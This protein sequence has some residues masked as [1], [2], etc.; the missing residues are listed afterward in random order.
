MLREKTNK[1]W[2]WLGAVLCGVIVLGALAA[3]IFLNLP[4]PPPPPPETEPTYPQPEEAEL[5][6]QDFQYDGQYL[7]CISAPSELGID[8]SQYQGDVDWAAVKEAGVEFVIIRLGGRGY[9]AEGV[10]YTDDMAETYYQGAKEAGLKVGVYFFSQAITA[11]E[12]QEEAELTLQIIE[13]WDLQMPVVYDWEV[14]EA[15]NSRTRNVD[16]RTITD[17]MKA[18]CRVIQ[19]AGREAMIYFNPDLSLEKVY[20]DEISIYRFWLAHYTEW[21]TYPYKVDMWQYTNVGSVPG[22]EGNVDL[23]LYFPEED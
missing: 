18:F 23:N 6:P 1:I 5:G 2:F 17:C 22:I 16:P 7:T 21:M 10:L 15:E 14:I 4:E 3:L 11:E 8:V 20:M 13:S 9:G 19:K 12:A